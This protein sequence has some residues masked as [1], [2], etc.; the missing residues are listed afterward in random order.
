MSIINFLQ[1][2]LLRHFV[3]PMLNFFRICS[4]VNFYFSLLEIKDKSTISR[5][6]HEINLLFNL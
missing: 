1:G 5:K 3:T 6:K 4:Q 2:N